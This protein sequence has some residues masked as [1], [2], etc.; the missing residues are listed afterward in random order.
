MSR[1][2]STSTPVTDPASA[3][4]QITAL[5]GRRVRFHTAGLADTCRYDLTTHLSIQAPFTITAEGEV[6][7]Y[8]LIYGDDAYLLIAGFG[9][10]PLSLC[11]VIE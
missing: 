2:R 8:E 6:T 10:A 5:L 3:I 1:A 9:R 7:G 4:E 11:T